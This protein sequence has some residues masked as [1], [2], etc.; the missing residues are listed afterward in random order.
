[1]NYKYDLATV[2]DNHESY[3]REKEINTTRE[4]KA[5]AKTD[6]K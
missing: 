4:I 1:V 3:A 2:E 5:L 6:F